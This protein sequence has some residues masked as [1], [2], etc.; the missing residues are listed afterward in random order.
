MFKDTG[1]L[2]RKSINLCCR[3]IFSYLEFV[4]FFER[5]VRFS[6]SLLHFLYLDKVT[7]FF[8]LVKLFTQQAFH[9]AG[10]GEVGTKQIT[11][12]ESHSNLDNHQYCSNFLSRI[13]Q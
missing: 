13:P 2:I 6:K 10:W 11:L 3:P 7:T 5:N 1:E 9:R 4:C 12:G 8:I